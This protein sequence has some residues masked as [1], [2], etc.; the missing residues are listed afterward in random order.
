MCNLYRLRTAPEEIASLFS[1]PADPGINVAKELYPGYPGLVVAEGRT[2]R[3]TWGFPLAMKGKQGQPL[4][5][6]AVTN[7]R[8]DKLHTGFWRDSFAKRRCLIPVSAWAEAEGEKGQM[9]RTWYAL[10][11]GQPFVV[12]GVWRP[13]VEWGDAYAMVMVDGCEQMA[14]VHDRMPT[15]LRPD[16]YGQWCEGTPELAFE[17]CRTCNDELVVERTEQRWA[18]ARQ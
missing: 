2:R 14:D 15:L 9:T 17:L 16:Q 8:E 18:A 4:K 6:K 3:M 7:A 5:P 1:A 10:P 11:G 12:A 13:T